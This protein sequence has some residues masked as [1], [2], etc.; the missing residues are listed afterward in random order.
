MSEQ[1][2][3]DCI[4]SLGYVFRACSGRGFLATA[5]P[6]PERPGDTRG[7]KAANHLNSRHLM[8]AQPTTYLLTALLC[9]GVPWILKV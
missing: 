2:L 4:P 5:H 9:T 7:K 1:I 8:D 3:V 6:Q